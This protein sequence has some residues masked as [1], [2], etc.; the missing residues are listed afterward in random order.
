MNRMM[1]ANQAPTSPQIA[2][3]V[4]AL[5]NQ[6]NK[7]T[8]ALVDMA[9]LDSAAIDS[10]ARRRGFNALAASPLAGLGEHAPHYVE[11]Q[12]E[13]VELAR[14]VTT[15]IRRTGDA[16]AISWIQTTATLAE[17]QQLAGYLSQVRIEDRRAPMHCRFADT[18]VLPHLLESL[19]PAQQRRVANVV[20]QWH[21]FDRRGS[22]V[23]WL[24]DPINQTSP[25]PD[26]NLRL[27][28]GQ[29]RH[30]RRRSEADAIF[31]LLVEQT[32]TLV[33]EGERGR[34]HAELST[35]L[36]TANGYA[37]TELEDRLQFVVLALSCGSDFHRLS[38]LDD[39]WRALKGGQA[40]LSTRMATWD[41][42]IWQQ[43]EQ[44]SGAAA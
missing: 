18:R 10:M 20:A 14:E 37:V 15:L 34:F 11:V 3:M 12:T 40:R 41:D 44:R 7:R 24:V 27:D 30:M 26:A 43:L 1:F 17:L 25:D 28:I 35:T 29:F 19:S 39:T 38:Y 2:D 36:D 8:W 22:P 5:S 42:A 4:L 13:G 33:P 16:P 23:R 31:K 21:W 6:A 9:L 32:P